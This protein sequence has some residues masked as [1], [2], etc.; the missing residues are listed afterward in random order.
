MSRGKISSALLAGGV[1]ILTL[2]ASGCL[3]K[4]ADD[5]QGAGLIGQTPDQIR[6][7][8]DSPDPAAVVAE[9]SGPGKNPIPWENRKETSEP[10]LPDEDTED[11]VRDLFKGL[12]QSRPDA[13]ERWFVPLVVLTK[14]KD[15]HMSSPA[16]QDR[17]VRSLH[18]DLLS[19]SRD[20]LARMLGRR[21]FG[22][23]TFE[24][25]EL[26]AC[27]FVGPGTD[28]N[29]LAYWTCE[30]NTVYYHV[31][32]DRKTLTVRRLINWGRSWYVMEW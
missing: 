32:G 19:R 7:A 29:R 21:A 11:R 18:A 31:D 8:T 13:I 24:S 17:A 28:F 30:K 6:R 10:P 2:L 12:T 26:G 5:G 1:A 27:R 14:I 4:P 25:L 9:A 23:A 15:M 20:R 3:P 22:T 16:E